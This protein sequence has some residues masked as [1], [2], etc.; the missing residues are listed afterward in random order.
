MKGAL[1]RA[2]F[3]A[4]ANPSCLDA[5]IDWHAPEQLLLLLIIGTVEE[6]EKESQQQPP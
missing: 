2:V 1:Y 6:K 3:V 4:E 5:C